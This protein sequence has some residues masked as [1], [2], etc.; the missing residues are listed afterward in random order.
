[1]RAWLITGGTGFIG[2]HLLATLQERKDLEIF[3]FGRKCPSG[4]PRER[5]VDGDLELPSGIQTT[6][7]SIHP[8]VIIHAAGRTPPAPADE[9]YR[10][11]TLATLHLLDAVESVGCTRR[12]VLIGSA[13]E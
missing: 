7:R 10:A 2:G 13:A 5:F 11:N 3:A 4:W 8:D 6:L 9:L 1:M 12:V